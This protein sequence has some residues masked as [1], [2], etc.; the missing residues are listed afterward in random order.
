MKVFI[1]A[2]FTDLI[3]IVEDIKLIS[4][5]FVSYDGRELY[6]ELHQNF[7]EKS[8]SQFVI[9]AVLPKLDRA[10]HTLGNSEAATQVKVWIESLGAPVQLVTDAPAYDWSLLHDFLEDYQAWPANLE[11]RP[12]DANHHEILQATDRYHDYQIVS[13]RHHALWDARALAAGFKIVQ[14]QHVPIKT[15]EIDGREHEYVELN[16]ELH[17]AFWRWRGN[18]G[19]TRVS[20]VPGLPAADFEKWKHKVESYQG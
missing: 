19:V 7:E 6:I 9:E 18:A 8:C 5:G 15:I 14:L 16:E 11:G 2:E 12:I 1:D 13:E 4:L 17:N 20:G 10:K 3:G